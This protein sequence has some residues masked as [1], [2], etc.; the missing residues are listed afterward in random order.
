MNTVKTVITALLSVMLMTGFL[1]VLLFIPASDWGWVNGWLL[2]ALAIPLTL[3]YWT[4]LPP[5]LLVPLIYALRIRKEE[6][7]LLRELDGYEE[8]R[9]RV[10][11]RLIPGIY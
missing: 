3:G 6:A 7:M 8:Y 1:S 2:M 10:V 5:A 4:G 11:Y 9:R